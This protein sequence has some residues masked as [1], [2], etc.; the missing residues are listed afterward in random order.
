MNDERKQALL[1]FIV[2]RSA[3]SVFE[4]AVMKERLSTF[5]IIREDEEWIP[6]P[7]RLKG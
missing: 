4:W 5:I 2:R 3:F 6:P 1:I 7:S